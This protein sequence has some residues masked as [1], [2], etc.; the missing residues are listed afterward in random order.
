V[1]R[2]RTKKQFACAGWQHE[3][4]ERGIK[5]EEYVAESERCGGNCRAGQSKVPR[6]S[7]AVKGH[8]Q[9]WPDYVELFF[10]AE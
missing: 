6:S 9:Q 3:I 8:Q 7:P 5:G 2:K 1:S 4:D 10:Y